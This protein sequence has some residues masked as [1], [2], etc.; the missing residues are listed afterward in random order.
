MAETT[1]RPKRRTI[2]TAVER[3]ERVTPHM[4][5]VVVGGDELDG[6]AVGEFT[7]HYVK[8]QLPPSGAGYA[9]PFDMEDLRASRPR[10]Q[11][12]RVRTYTVRAWDA[13]R[14]QLT[15]DVIVHG[16]EGVAGPWAAAVQPGDLLQLMGPGGAYSPDPDAAW[17]LMVG[18]MSVLP[19]IG[20]SLPRVPAGV[21][22]HVIVELDDDADRQQLTSPGDLHVTWLRSDGSDTVLLE[23]VQALAFPD[24][25]V[26]AFVH[27]E[28]SAVRALR[29]HLLV[30]RGVP[31]EALS[32]SGYWKRTR[33]DEE[34]RADKQEW[35]RLVEEDAAAA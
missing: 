4:V 20:A 1:A 11:W 9:P 12:P 33:T 19:A 14:R 15:L 18:D 27:G 17:H 25:P 35:N 5:R 34:W 8:L 30:D 3:V 6:F 26:H 31:R 7:D 24:G 21:P 2:H 32:V 22:V 23:A 29:R 13:E 10:E 28:A 16:D